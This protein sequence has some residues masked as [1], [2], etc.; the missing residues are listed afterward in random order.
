MAIF[1]GQDGHIW[2]S[3]WSYLV[4]KMV[5]SVRN[6]QVALLHQNPIFWGLLNKIC[7]EL[8]VEEVYCLRQA[9]I[10]VFISTEGALR[11]LTTYDN[12]PC[13]PTNPSHKVSLII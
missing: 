2:W 7:V 1:G 6:V 3:R 13:I 10:K 5:R 9:K 12:H 11:L 8:N 4:V